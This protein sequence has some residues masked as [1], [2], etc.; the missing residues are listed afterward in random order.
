[1]FLGI[2]QHNS[3]HCGTSWC[4]NACY[5]SILSPHKLACVYTLVSQWAPVL[6]HHRICDPRII[7][8]FKLQ[9]LTSWNCYVV[10]LISV[11]CIYNY[12]LYGFHP[13]VY[14]SLKDYDFEAVYTTIN[15]ESK[16]DRHQHVN[17]CFILLLMTSPH[18][19]TLIWVIFRHTWI[20][21]VSFWTASLIQ[22]EFILC[23]HCYAILMTHF[24]IYNIFRY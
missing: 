9:V 21:G 20:F 6:H 14:S 19:S 7:R 22:Y 11:W 1:M 12:H 8:H 4:H 16:Q 18:V 3:G 17:I 2:W 5:S 10:H 15:S 13:V 24:D 23:P